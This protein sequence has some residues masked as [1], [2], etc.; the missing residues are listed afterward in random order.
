MFGVL[1]LTAILAASCKEV[2][3][4][5]DVKNT[6]DL[7]EDDDDFD[8]SVFDKTP[9]ERK[10]QSEGKLA[11]S[12]VNAVKTFK[13][14]NDNFSLTSLLSSLFGRPQRT[15][16]RIPESR[17]TIEPDEA[18][19]KNNASN[20]VLNLNKDPNESFLNP[21]M[22]ANESILNS[23]K[24]TNKSILNS[25]KD[26]NET[27]LNSNKDTNDAESVDENETYEELLS[28]DSFLTDDSEEEITPVKSDGEMAAT[29]LKQI[30]LTTKAVEQTT[31]SN[32]H[33]I[34]KRVPILS[35]RAKSLNDITKMSNA[36]LS[37]T[38]A[39]IDQFLSVDNLKNVTGVDKFLEVYSA[40]RLVENWGAIKGVVEPACRH[41]LGLYLMG[42]T[43][44]EL[45]ALK[46]E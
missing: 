8:F 22:D 16:R 27:I 12:I 40:Q 21:N 35:R 42:L 38:D 2:N 15:K 20:D 3:K 1:V 6:T 18:S 32:I 23:N 10:K 14:E 26:P 24:D 33:R 29:E 44:H 11:D 7:E 13:R 25:N 39:N 28:F 34:P 5:A 9:A 46:S 4:T 37:A 41:Q 43:K 30:I 17:S 19:L 45:W 36:E 31:K